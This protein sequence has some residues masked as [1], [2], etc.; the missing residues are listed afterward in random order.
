MVHG[1]RAIEE[2]RGRF[3]IR[4]GLQGPQ[5]VG[6]MITATRSRHWH[7]AGTRAFEK[8]AV[9]QLGHIIML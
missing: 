1:E 5:A 3:A 2:V 6:V 9:E 7:A 4:L 8:P